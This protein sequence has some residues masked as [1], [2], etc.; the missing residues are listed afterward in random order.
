MRLPYVLPIRIMAPVVSVLSTSLVAV[1]ALS[2]VEPVTTSGPTGTVMQLVAAGA[3]DLGRRV[4]AEED[5]LRAEGLGPAE[6]RAHVRRG[7]AG[8]D[9]QH[10]VVGPDTR[11]SSMS[12]IAGV[13]VV[14]GA[15]DRA[16][17]G[18]VARRR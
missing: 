5:R 16:Y 12:P 17:Q 14:L 6:R 7:A 3:Q 4:Q 11:R 1:P 2:R 8:G 9:A 18:P 10:D 15:L 13:E